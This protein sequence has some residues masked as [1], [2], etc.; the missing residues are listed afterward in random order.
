MI[1]DLRLV[2]SLL[3]SLC[4]VSS[5]AFACC[6][7]DERLAIEREQLVARIDVLAFANGDVGIFPEM[8]GVISTFCAPT[9]A[10]S[11]AI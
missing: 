1:S 4:A 7:A 10:L 8:S 2:F 5:L 3:K 11:V 6:C 9:Y